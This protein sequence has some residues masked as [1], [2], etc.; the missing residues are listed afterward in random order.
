MPQSVRMDQ[1]K[2]ESLLV[3]ADRMADFVLKCFDL[4]L[5]SQPGR[6]LYERA[7]GTYI[8]TEVGDMPMAE[9]YDALKT[10]PVF[11]PTLAHD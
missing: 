4:T 3:D 6:D 1:K 7:F 10:E 8:R 2:A 9:I 11:D 5:E